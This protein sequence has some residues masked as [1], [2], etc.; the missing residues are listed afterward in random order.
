MPI[1]GYEPTSLTVHIKGTYLTNAL[2]TLMIDNHVVVD[3]PP[4]GVASNTNTIS[5]AGIPP[6][7]IASSPSVVIVQIAVD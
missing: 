2:T 4:D 1:K 5:I 7:T 3:V 6:P